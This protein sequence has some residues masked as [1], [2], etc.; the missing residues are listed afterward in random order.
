VPPNRKHLND[1]DEG[2]RDPKPPDGPSNDRRHIG[3]FPPNKSL[4]S[5]EMR[6]GNPTSGA[7]LHPFRAR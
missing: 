3:R 7:V 2:N 5:K 6:H 4:G 1:P